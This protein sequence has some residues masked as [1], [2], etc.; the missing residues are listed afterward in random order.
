MK[1][2]SQGLTQGFGRRVLTMQKN[3]PRT[4]FILGIAGVVG[5]TILACRATLKLEKTL[6]EFKNDVE[7]VNDRHAI[8][9]PSSSTKTTYNKDMAV[10]YTKGTAK[11]VRLYA[12]AIVL[13]GLSVAA[14]TGSHITLTR[15]NAALTAAYSA[16]STSFE[17]YRERVRKEVGEE[18]ERDIHQ[19]IVTEK[20]AID[21]KTEIV[22]STD[23]NK[24]SIYA[25]FFDEYNVNWE[26]NPEFNKLFIQS[27]QNYM[28]HLLHARGH[29]FLNE[30]YDQLGIPR[31]QAGQF[32]GWVVNQ[33]GDNFIDLGIFDVRNSAFVNG[34]E[35]SI[36]LDF[37][38]DGVVYDK[39]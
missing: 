5:T 34:W 7:A 27:Q 10:V 29:V 8:E 30:V 36:L 16:L 4:L 25:R 35:R 38:V 19:G 14:L 20:M 28:N 31:S 17:S 24:I 11:V 1:L 21:G 15:R 6:T 22:R 13:G 2:I 32:V 33:G 18:K 23:P 39:I 9:K 3:S 26:K 37:N 12:P